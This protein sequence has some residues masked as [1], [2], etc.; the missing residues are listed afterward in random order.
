FGGQA[1]RHRGN[2]GARPA[3]A[4]VPVRLRRRAH[5]REPPPLVTSPPE[6][7]AVF[8]RDG[9]APS[10]LAV[11]DR[12]TTLIHF[13]R[14]AETQAGTTAFHPSQLRLLDKTIEKLQLL[15]ENGYA[16]AIATNQ[17]GPTKEHFPRAAVLR[18][19][20]ALV[21]KLAGRGVRIARVE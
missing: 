9:T 4:P 3:A 8:D 13:V 14:A 15:T 17:P 16:L 1:P 7:L 10:K 6:K 11:F 19:N 20:E 18:T 5:R 12:D 2:G 21:E